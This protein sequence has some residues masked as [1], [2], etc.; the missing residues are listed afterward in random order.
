MQIDPTL[1]DKQLV[2][3]NGDNTQISPM[4]GLDFGDKTDWKPNW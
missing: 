2:L 1:I 4:A 3:G